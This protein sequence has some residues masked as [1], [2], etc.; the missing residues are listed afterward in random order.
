[1]AGRTL[2]EE[3]AQDRRCCRSAL[4]RRFKRAVSH[5]GPRADRRT[6]GRLR[7]QLSYP[8]AAFARTGSACAFEAIPSP[9]KFRLQNPVHRMR[10][11]F[12]RR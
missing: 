7:N 11:T 2:V 10:S 8:T 4:V 9:S 5:S 6:H 12:L 1:M 3:N